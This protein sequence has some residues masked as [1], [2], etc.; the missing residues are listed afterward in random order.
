MTVVSVQGQARDATSWLAL[1]RKCEDLGF[2][3]LLAADHP[4]ARP[5]P[6]VVLAAAA[7][8]TSRIGLGSYVSNGGI[9]E[10]L[11]LAS[12]VAT[13]DLVSGGRARLGLGAGHTPAEWL[14]VGRERPS[15]TDRVDRCIAMAEVI[16]DLLAGSDVDVD[17]QVLKVRGRLAGPI[18]VSSRI[19]VTIGGGNSRLMR[20]AGE[21]ADIVGLT[22]LGRTLPDGYGHEARWRIEQFQSQLDHVHAGAANRDGEPVL[23][24]LVQMVAVTDDPGQAVAE[25]SAELGV[26]EEDLLSIPFLLVGNEKEI[27]EAL[28]ERRRRWGISR[29][30]VRED[31]IEALAP[32]LP[33]IASID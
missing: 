26:G 14:N 17:T 19:P 33:Q 15:V 20:W 1:A 32:L 18:P 12:D 22:G 29:L 8:V 9:R 10:P 11:L 2:D 25:L 27:V 31:A 28:V 3:S 16:R 4:G 13:L 21:H 24:A 7:A 23:E 6:F 5:S 30:V